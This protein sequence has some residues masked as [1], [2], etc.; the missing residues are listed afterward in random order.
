MHPGPGAVPPLVCRGDEPFLGRDAG[1]RAP[2]IGDDDV[3]DA[4][5]PGI[6]LYEAWRI[7]LGGVAQLENVARDARAQ[8]L[9]LGLNFG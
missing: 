6:V 4:P 8:A 9:Q 2:G 7:R 5:A 3:V 1:K